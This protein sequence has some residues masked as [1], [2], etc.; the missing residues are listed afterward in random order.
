MARMASGKVGHLPLPRES[1]RAAAPAGAAPGLHA[2]TMP[3]TLAD[4]PRT[5]EQIRSLLATDREAE[6]LAAAHE[7]AAL[8]PGRAEVLNDLGV[9]QARAGRLSEARQSFEQALRTHPVI[10]TAY[11][12]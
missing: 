8:L 3:A 9:L 5:R 4:L 2:V 11:D 12:N 6:A 1:A 10:A 7:L